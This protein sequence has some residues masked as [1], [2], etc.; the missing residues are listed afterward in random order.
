M[1]KQI[2]LSLANCSFIKR[3]ENLLIT[4]KTGS[5][6]S[7]LALAIGRQACYMGIRTIYH[8]M[9]KFIEKVA[10]SKVDGRFI[11]LINQIEKLDLIIMDDFGL[12]PLDQNTRLAL[13]QILEDCYQRKTVIVTSQLPVTK[14]S[15]AVNASI[16]AIPN[17]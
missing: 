15:S 12:Q 16:G 3:A 2:L 13:L 9:N 14:F 17:C 10:L 11:K 5:G 7:Y 8:A 4:G 6:K 1:N